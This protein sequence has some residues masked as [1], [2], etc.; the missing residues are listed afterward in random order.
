MACEP[1]RTARGTYLPDLS[2]FA[3][4]RPSGHQPPSQPEPSALLLI[5]IMHVCTQLQLHDGS[6]CRKLCPMRSG[7]SMGKEASNRDVGDRKSYWYRTGTVSRNTGL[8]SIRS[9]RST[10]QPISGWTAHTT[11]QT[12]TEP[13]SAVLLTTNTANMAVPVQL[14]IGTSATES[15]L[16]RPCK[17]RWGGGRRW[18]GN[19]RLSQGVATA[20]QYGTASPHPLLV[21]TQHLRVESSRQPLLTGTYRR[22]PGQIRCG[23]HTTKHKQKL[24]LLCRARPRHTPAHASESLQVTASSPMVVASSS[25]VAVNAQR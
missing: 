16:Q 5:T 9:P 24:C 17:H 6:L 19:F 3:Q 22:S 15:G 25:S 11:R 4:T 1:A 23:V 10:Q 21:H 14:A 12:L 2:L 7:R 13:A 8:S 20:Y 18:T